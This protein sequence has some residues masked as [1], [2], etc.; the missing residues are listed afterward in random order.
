MGQG[1]DTSTRA[2][3]W[4]ISS[5]DSAC[6]TSPYAGR[7]SHRNTS[8]EKSS[9]LDLMCGQ[10]G[11]NQSEERCVATKMEA[12]AREGRVR[13][14]VPGRRQLLRPTGAVLLR[15]CRRST[16]VSLLKS[17]SEHMLWFKLLHGCYSALKIGFF[18][19]S[20]GCLQWVATPSGVS[21]ISGR[22]YLDLTRTSSN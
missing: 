9:W 5:M 6:H 2:G 14:S 11:A 16:L 19:R 15:C 1:L 18:L 3:L 12:R 10:T 20:G 22:W 8:G 17:S 7:K 13:V 4:N 21:W